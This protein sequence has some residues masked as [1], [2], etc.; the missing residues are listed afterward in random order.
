MLMAPGI[1]LARIKKCFTSVFAS[2][3]IATRMEM[4]IWQLCV[5]RCVP[6]FIFWEFGYD[7]TRGQYGDKG[8]SKDC[9]G[10]LA[11]VIRETADK[12]CQGR[13]ITILCGGSSRQMATYI[14]PRVI[15]QLVQ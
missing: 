12:V 10:K 2:K 14:I 11:E 3:I 9:H 13:L 4:L 1:Y 6:E 8:V 7:A 5:H 15:K